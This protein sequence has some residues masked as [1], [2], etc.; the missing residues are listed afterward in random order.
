MKMYAAIW[1]AISL[2]LLSAQPAAAAGCRDI[3]FE[4]TPFTVCEADPKTEEIRLFLND[5]EGRPLG[6]FDNVEATLEARGRSLRFAM[7]AGMYHPDRRPVGLYVEDGVEIGRIVTRDG[8]GN[9]GL[10]PNGVLC[11]GDDRARIVES[12][13]F[14][15][16]RP[17]CRY[18]TQS[19]PMLVIDG[20]L[21]PRFLPNSSSRHVRNG[22]GVTPDGTLIAAISNRPVNFHRFGRLF[23]DVLG[24]P[25]ALY[26]DG[27]ISGLYAPGM[28]RHDLG[29]PMG[30][31]LGVVA[32]AD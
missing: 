5:G 6:T 15:R 10:L 26:M 32:P 23:R 16:E 13:R 2:A 18:A 7:N 20:D 27:R 31:I 3:V 14:D 12:R 9:F 11:L 17:G 24:T 1:T 21:H 28:G 8:P 22:V 30:P 25:N 29:F 4:D 19:G